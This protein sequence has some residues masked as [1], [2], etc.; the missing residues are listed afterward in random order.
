MNPKPITDRELAEIEATAYGWLAEPE[1]EFFPGAS[2]RVESAYIKLREEKAVRTVQPNRD[3]L[4]FFYLGEDDLPVGISMLEPVTGTA[5]TEIIYRLLRGPDG[6]PQAVDRRV[7]YSFSIEAVDETLHK[8]KDANR[9]L[10][11]GAAR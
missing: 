3:L 4:V 1:V 7:R 10:L 6:S 11:A 2:G 9:E 8:I 5:G